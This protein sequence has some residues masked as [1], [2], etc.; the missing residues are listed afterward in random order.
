MSNDDTPGDAP[1][2]PSGDAP[3]STPDDHEP[4]FVRS[5]WGTNRYVCNPRNPAGMTL[6]VLSLCLAAGFLH[7]LSDSSAWTEDELREAAHEATGVLAEEPH[8]FPSHL[9][10]AEWLEERVEEAVDEAG[11]LNVAPGLRVEPAEQFGHHRITTT[12]TRAVF[13]LRVELSAADPEEDSDA[14][15]GTVSGERPVPR[16]D[17]TATAAEGGC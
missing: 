2:S 17:L 10:H 14:G 15:H 4:V 8:S 7:H 1:G 5:P 16:Y 11:G 13:C 6:I 12:D 9:G 3:G